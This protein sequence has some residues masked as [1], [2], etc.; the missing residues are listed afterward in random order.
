MASNNVYEI[1]TDRIIAELEKGIIP[2]KR[3][4]V[5]VGK[6]YGKAVSHTNGKPYSLLNQL[7]LG[8]PG[9]YIT[10]NQCKK[11]GGNVKK[12]A[13]AR[14]VCFWKMLP[15]D[16]TDADGAPIIDE[17]TGKTAQKVIPYLKYY[18]VFHIDD[19]DG[20]K[21]KYSNVTTPATP[22]TVAEIN[23][24][25]EKV[26][27]DYIAREGITLEEE[28]SD[29]A[30]YSPAADL[31]HLPIRKQFEST[32]EYYSTA[33]HESVHST[34]HKSRL[35]RLTT[36]RAAAFGGSDYSKEELVAELGAASICHALGLETDSSFKNS[37]AYIQSWLKALRNDKRMVV[38][39][40]S[41]AEKAVA[42]IFGETDT[43]EAADVAEA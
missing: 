3:P 7:L 16:K 17:K 14:M 6:G 8:K 15:V 31:I 22:A 13:K 24:K 32:A 19:C 27:R 2:W 26:L 40:A 28:E 1:I 18:N 21:A 37:A 11:E 25:A 30:Y 5:C 9:E 34:G 23:D 36:G 39:A 35:D 4:W 38:T 33:F 41:K 20:I 29:E 42:R 10:W 43:A 12:G